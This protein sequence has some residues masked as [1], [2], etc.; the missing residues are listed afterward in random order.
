M[1]ETLFEKASAVIHH[2]V[3]P[4]AGERERYLVHC[5]NE[6]YTRGNLKKMAA[7]LLAVV[8]ELKDYPDLRVGEE[9]I[10]SATQR[11][12]RMHRQ[13]SKAGD[14]RKFR[15]LFEREA[16]RWLRF[17]GRFQESIV[18]P[19]RLADSLEDFVAWMERERGLSLATIDNRRRHV[20][21][22][23]R[24][25]GDQ[26][27]P[28]SS[29]RLTD[30]DVFL[31]AC[32][33]RGLSR[34]TI[35]IHSSAIRSFLKYAG[36]QGWCSPSIVDGIH[37]PRIYAQETLPTGPSW[38][39]IKR[40]LS[41]LDTDNP[42]DIR[43]RAIITLFATYG[44]RASEVSRLRLE[45]IDWEH[46]QIVV[47][48][49]K[50]RQGQPYPLVPEAGRAIVR[51]LKEVRPECRY[52]EL[53]INILAPRRPVSRKNLYRLVAARMKRLGIKSLPHYGPHALRHACAQHLVSKGFTLKEIGDHLGHRSPSATR[54][55]AKV[56]LAG[57]REV[58]N[59][60][61]G[62]VL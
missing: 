5:A 27:R 50:S 1:F 59:F 9:Q 45:D 20:E 44:F 29:V 21:P 40:L 53:F 42:V 35:K 10:Q 47:P 3:A 16:K 55:Y 46:D 14:V 43:D 51:Y 19:L 26:R 13:Y 6:G 15:K 62:G 54:I 12:A 49:H 18:K 17:L 61:L 4:H 33:A 48:R 2:K 36:S 25:F 22:F 37:G 58:A 24:W 8:H 39:E 34:T 57:L 38:D 52:R 31:A 11:A 60:D 56:D 30:V 32:H 7:I 23:L 28:I 41:S